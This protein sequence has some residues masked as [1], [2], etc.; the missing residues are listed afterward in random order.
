[1]NCFFRHW[2]LIPRH[3]RHA[4][5]PVA[6]RAIFAVQPQTRRAV[7]TTNFSFA[8]WRPSVIRLPSAVEAN[9]HWGLSARF[10]RGTYRHASSTSL[11]STPPESTRGTSLE[12]SPSTTVFPLGTNR[13]GSN[14]P[15]R[16]S[17]YS[18]RNRSTANVPNN[19]SAI[20]SYPPSAYQ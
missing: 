13:S 9:P 20:A 10:S 18:S 14:V 8:H 17:S 1:R 2:P 16:S 6:T 19:F 4:S 12:L 15:E 11:S 3:W 7:S 5:S